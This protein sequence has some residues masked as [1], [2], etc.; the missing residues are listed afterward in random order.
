MPASQI[1]LA[2]TPGAAI[3]NQLAGVWSE[4]AFAVVV[5][6]DGVMASYARPFQ[7]VDFYERSSPIIELSLPAN[8]AP[9]KFT[10]IGDARSRGANVRLFIGQEREA[11]AEKGPKNFYH[12]MVLDTSRG[13]TH[14][15]CHDLMTREAMM[16]CFESLAEDGILLIQISSR[17]YDLGPAVGDVA[18]SLNLSAA[19][20]RD[21]PN[22]A[23]AH[24]HFASDWVLVA[25]RP[26]LLQAVKAR[27]PP[28][29]RGAGIQWQSLQPTGSAPWADGERYRLRRW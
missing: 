23:T 18:H 8:G 20:L 28:P 26:E 12:A 6:N 3:Y 21:S 14:I 15:V 29:A 16:L 9:A 19:R 25:R 13:S 4:P 5:V 22:R 24:P 17:H 11:L 27:I 7:T 1:G 2:A 10:F